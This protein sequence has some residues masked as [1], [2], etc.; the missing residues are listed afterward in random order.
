MVM[1]FSVRSTTLKQNLS[2]DFNSQLRI[3]KQKNS[4]NALENSCFIVTLFF[5]KE[6]AELI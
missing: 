1:P 2:A 6:F 4:N 5:K 3:Y